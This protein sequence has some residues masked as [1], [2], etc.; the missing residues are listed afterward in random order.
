MLLHAYE[1]P[2]L[3]VTCYERAVQLAPDVLGWVYLAGVVHAELG[4]Y[5]QAASVFRRALRIDGSYLPARLKLA[6]ALLSGG[7]APASRVVYEELLQGY[8]ELSLARYGLG[9]ALASLGDAAGALAAYEQAIHLAPQFGAAHYAL[10][11]AYRDAG[12]SERALAHLEAYRRLGPRRPELPDPLL[13]DVRALAGTA[14]Q[15][16]AAGARLASLGK[17]N[18]AIA[19]HVKALE[20]DPDASQAHV[21][22]ISLYGSAGRAQEA[23]FHYQHALKRGSHLGD[24]HY[25]FGVLLASSGRKP[26]AVT[27][28]RR[29]LEADGFHVK[30][31]NNLGA[32][33][34][35]QGK[36]EAAAG[37]FRQAL[38]SDPQHRS[39]RFSLARVLLE[40][41]RPSE[42]IEHLE[43]LLARES[44]DTPRQ[45]HALAVAWLAAGNAARAIEY[46]EDAQRHAMRLGQVG[47]AETIGRTLDRLRAAK[48]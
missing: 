38:A 34:A 40:T 10:G 4:D 27:A 7:N 8:P 32:L 37:H 18:E 15:L 30:A 11:L 5:L 31:H 42:A 25:N 16:I 29:A 3:A 44:A 45:K 1:Q 13:D 43:K 22:L 6:E 36:R 26:E 33:L 9:R 35:E 20:S 24:A 41:G 48:R 2:G 47:L 39:A 17:T 19:L 14:R 12:S 28:F 23:E 21:N 46:A